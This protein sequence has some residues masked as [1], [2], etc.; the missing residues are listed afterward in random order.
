MLTPNL[1]IDVDRYIDFIS[2]KGNYKKIK[3]PY[4]FRLSS[5]KILSLDDIKIELEKTLKNKN[6][7]INTIIH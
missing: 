6:L 1:P 4:L 7:E 5:N 2:A 3:Y